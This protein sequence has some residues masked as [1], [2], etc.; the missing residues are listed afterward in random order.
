MIERHRLGELDDFAQWKSIRRRYCSPRGTLRS[1]SIFHCQNLY[2]G[3]DFPSLPNLTDP[4]CRRYCFPH[5][6]STSSI[7]SIVFHPLRTSMTSIISPSQN[8]YYAAYLP[9]PALLPCLRFFPHS[10]PLAP[11]SSHTLPPT[12]YI[13]NT[14]VHS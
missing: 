11:S 6:P 7:L 2:E 3:N 8:P 5:S 13:S 10:H 9:F 1:T 4:L 14:A 12:K